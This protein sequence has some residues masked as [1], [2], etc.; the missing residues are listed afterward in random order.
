M[1]SNVGA[2]GIIDPEGMVS[3]LDCQDIAVEFC[4]ATFVQLNRVS[5]S[6]VDSE[7]L[8]LDVLVP[9]VGMRGLEGFLGRE[10][11]ALLAVNDEVVQE[12]F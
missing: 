12:V 9:G 7:D 8:F 1:H 4:R 2:E 10:I 6:L 5:E 3:T 11:C